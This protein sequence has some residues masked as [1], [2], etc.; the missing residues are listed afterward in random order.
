MKSSIYITLEALLTLILL[1]KN[2]EDF[3]FISYT[4]NNFQMILNKLQ[5]KFRTPTKSIIPL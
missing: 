1:N 2:V 4:A 3:A 5:P